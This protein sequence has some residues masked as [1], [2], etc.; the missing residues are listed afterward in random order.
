LSSVKLRNNT[1]LMRKFQPSK[2]NIS[3]ERDGNQPSPFVVDLNSRT[4]QTEIKKTKHNILKEEYY[5]F[6]NAG[7]SLE[8]ARDEQG[9]RKDTHLQKLI[10]NAS[11][12]ISLF[13]VI[14]TMFSWPIILI[15]KIF[16]KSCYGVGFL[17]VSLLRRILFLPK[18]LVKLVKKIFIKKTFYEKVWASVKSLKTKSP[19]SKPKARFSFFQIFK[20]NKKI[21]FR[22]HP[23][24]TFAVVLLILII[25]FKLLS[26]YKSIDNLKGKVLGA[27]ENAING[28]FSAGNS[29]KNL[30]FKTASENFSQAGTN[31][32]LAQS[33]LSQINDLLLTL[34]SIAPNK[35]LRIASQS[36]NILAAG[37]AASSLGKNLSLAVD[38]LLKKGDE[39]RNIA[40]ILANF[41]LYGNHSINDAER[42]NQQLSKINYQD[43]PEQYQEE[44]IMMRE[45]SVFLEKSLTEFLDLVENLKILLGVEQDKR[46]L[47]IFQNNAELRATGGF[48]GSFALVDFSKG[49]IKQIETPGGGSYDTEAG[50]RE[51][52]IAPKPLQMLN[53]LWHFWDANWWPDWP[54]SARKI[55]WFYEKS[56]G[57][58][59]DGVIS[60]TPTVMEEILKVVGPIDMTEKYG[61]II[62]A[63]NFWQVTQKFSEQK[64]DVTKEPKKH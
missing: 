19:F 55:M 3:I 13:K 1:I 20:K 42:L 10:S 60:L 34:A 63:N 11:R 39:Q 41:N 51:K 30:N 21:E 24:A 9:D 61:V 8:P 33:Q 12:F 48:F 53:P 7:A 6:F 15:G 46:Y 62:D 32:L 52:I 26:Y 36:K 27:T 5:K 31:F 40:E 16:Y 43:L 4:L 35:D 18:S 23:V 64:E 57:P 29:A 14:R 38:S 58:T 47:L 25:P 2:K 17:S 45:K 22:W 56:N 28:L 44:F 54:T 59:V 37:E 49:K 50:L